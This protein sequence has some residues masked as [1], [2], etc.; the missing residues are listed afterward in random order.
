MEKPAKLRCIEFMRPEPV[1]DVIKSSGIV[2]IPVS[3][4]VEWHG[5]HLPMGTDGI[6]AEECAKAMAEIFDACYFRCLPLGLD[7][8]RNEKQLKSWGF[9]PET[10]IPFNFI[11]EFAE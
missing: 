2:F 9:P 5:P 3:P 8:I 7:Q 4:R 11:L 1:R 6:I 10:S